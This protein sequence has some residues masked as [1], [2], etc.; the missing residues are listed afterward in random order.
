MHKPLLDMAGKYPILAN[1][2]PGH[3]RSSFPNLHPYVGSRVRKIDRLDLIFVSETF[4]RA[5]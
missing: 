5:M 3:R 4:F 1:V 2:N